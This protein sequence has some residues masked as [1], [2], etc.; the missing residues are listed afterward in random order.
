MDI[1]PSTLLH[2]EKEANKI[3]I[4]NGWDEDFKKDLIN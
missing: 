2:I 4:E 3:C 1:S